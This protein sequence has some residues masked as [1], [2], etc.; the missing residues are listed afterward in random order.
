MKVMGRQSATRS[1]AKLLL[2]L[3]LGGAVFS[4]T[5]ARSAELLVS[6][7][8]SL[9]EAFTELATLF[10][11]ENPGV[12]VIGN[13]ASS[14]ALYR[15]LEQGAPADVFASANPRW[16]A[17]AIGRGLVRRA[18]SQQFV[19][20]ELV[21]A[22]PVAGRVAISGL[23]DLKSPA[24]TRVGIG[25]PETVPAGR[26][27]KEALEAVGIWQEL[28]NK[29]IFGDNVRQILD[30]LRRGEVDGGFI[31]ATDAVKGGAA[32]QVVE[33]MPLKESPA[34]LIAPLAKSRQP[35]LARRFVELTI[36]DRGGA[37]LARHGFKPNRSRQFARSM[38]PFGLSQPS[39]PGSLPGS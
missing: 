28:T 8:A 11:Q 2:V 18:E 10:E 9:N 6:A 12:K 37:I 35:E 24:V 29:M 19:T 34:Y 16:M 26:Y 15:Q 14:G 1:L 30:Y 5:P 17:G 4:A 33:I 23:N 21:L 20:N 27:A 38:R 7:A 36:S 22:V 25:T 13:F 3:L 31:Y 32:V 39:A